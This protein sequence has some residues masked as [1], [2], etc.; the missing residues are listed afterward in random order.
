[1]ML[2]ILTKKPIYYY[3][4]VVSLSVELSLVNFGNILFLNS[5]SKTNQ[6]CSDIIIESQHK[7]FYNVKNIT[8]SMIILNTDQLHT[9]LS[10]LNLTAA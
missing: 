9:H 8:F 2:L 5:Q 4:I 1:M 7:R 10:Q 3:I 6:T